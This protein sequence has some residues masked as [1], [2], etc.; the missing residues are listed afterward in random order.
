MQS[1]V[2][3]NVK[4]LKTLHIGAVMIKCRKSEKVIFMKGQ[5]ERGAGRKKQFTE[6]IIYEIKEKYQ[7]GEKILQLAKE[8]QV[9]R[10]TISAYLHEERCEGTVFHSLNGWKRK[11][12]EFQNLPFDDYRMR[13]EYMHDEQ[14]CSVILVDFLHQRIQVKNYTDFPVHRAFGIKA[15]P[16]W[17]DFEYF[18][19]DRCLP[20]SRFGIREILKEMDLNVFD[21]ISIIEKTE[22]RMAEDRQW[23]RIYYYR[24]EWEKYE[25]NS[26]SK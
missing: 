2:I 15:L 3:R 26:D 20:E 21:P 18:L 23:I 22:G 16:D 11:N 4:K 9:S 6:Q 7:A 8:Y 19:R 13:M 1:E 5:N 24:K 14:C 12:A 17:D 10:Q 25:T